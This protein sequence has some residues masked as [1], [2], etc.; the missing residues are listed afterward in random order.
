MG[1]KVT[2]NLFYYVILLSIININA[3]FFSSSSNSAVVSHARLARMD[4]SMILWSP[5]E[6]GF[7]RINRYHAIGIV[8]CNPPPL[9]L[10]AYEVEQED[11]LCEWHSYIKYTLKKCYCIMQSNTKPSIIYHYELAFAQN[12]K[13]LYFSE[14]K[15]TLVNKQR[16]KAK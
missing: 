14:A 11:K 3:L 7:V 5:A 9:R 13:L 6:Q 16:L 10:W 15:R 2:C 12:K 8:L 1:L 4:Q